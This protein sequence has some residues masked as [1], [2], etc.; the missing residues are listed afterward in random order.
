MD[1]R[2]SRSSQ[3]ASLDLSDL[4]RLWQPSFQRTAR[5]ISVADPESGLLR[6]VNPAFA[7]MHGG[8]PEDFNGEPLISVFTP[9]SAARIPALAK[10]VHE[11][12]YV[13]YHADHVRLDG[14]VFPVATEVM[15]V[16]DDDGRLLYRI[17][18][19][20]DLSGQRLVEGRKRE[21]ERLFE[22][23]FAEAP[24]G[25]ALLDIDGTWLRA[26]RALCEITGYSEAELR[27]RKFADI[28]HPDDREGD[29]DSAERLLA[30]EIE[31]DQIEKRYI[32]KDG[33][34]VWVL[35]SGSLVRSE[36]GTPLHYIS[37][38]QDISARKQMEADLAEA[39]RGFELTRDMLCTATF[40]GYLD[41][42]NGS[43]TEIL[44]WT[45]D[46]LRS[47][48][49]I[50]FVH[51]DDRE[52]TL[53]ETAKFAEG[54]ESRFFRNRWQTK[55]GDWCWLS[56]SA[57]GVLEEER[58]FCAA[59]EAN[60]RVA[61]ERALELRGEVIG[62]MTEGVCLVTIDDMRIVY[63]N[64][65]LEKIL[66]YDPGELNELDALEVMRPTDLSEEEERIRDRTEKTLREQG[67]ASYEGRR[68]RSDGEK[69]WCRTTT[70]T[71]DHP[72][73]GSVW[74]VVMQ[75]ITEERRGRE[76]RAELERG[77][78]E[79]FGSV[80]HEL[81]TPLT[82]ILGF[83]ALL[84]EDSERLG[85]ENREY[86]S[87]IERNARRQLRLVEDLLSIA[88]IQ[89]GE[90]TLNR[91]DLDLAA[92]VGDAV[93]ELRPVSEE[94]EIKL[95][96]EFGGTIR[97]SG[98]ADRL[99][100]VVANLLSNAIKFTPRAGRVEVRLEAHGGEAVLTVSDSGPGI[101]A[102][103]RSRLFERLYR[104]DA[105]KSKRVSGAGL[106][107]AIT[108]S[109]VEAHSGRIEVSDSAEPGT[110][111]VVTLPLSQASDIVADGGRSRTE[112]K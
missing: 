30:G 16:R 25:M 36:D 53:K 104:A 57:V 111:F 82:S 51:P 112:G 52:R 110:T 58:V 94:K 17:G 8:A 89:S 109:I 67:S 14:S 5:G 90:F 107:L 79:F 95:S 105:A 10:R 50:D 84:R 92:V 9:E 98:D 49:F 66:G 3:A 40:D 21:A 101:D 70:T 34:P 62:N 11:E 37:H 63:A 73:F 93:E 96:A 32:R 27:R 15:V 76:A 31:S 60:D 20:E 97:M 88:R 35:L 54:G 46:E 45:E 42:I 23:A 65:S 28:T 43:W 68:T 39:A 6:L 72:D 81:R 48:R 100:Q 69:I 108:K 13:T 24:V 61:I 99:A 41:R 77:R 26:N 64:P 71:F 12:G 86:V 83:T 4:E 103:D 80:S 55:D 85:E 59:R 75:D 19:I 18:W 91:A 29:L 38:V 2:L 87:V 44:G 22:A 1:T 7:R 78:S 106:G 56:W 33:E 74:V 102:A 47:R